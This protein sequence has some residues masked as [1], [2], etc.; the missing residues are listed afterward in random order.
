MRQ[1]G[2]DFVLFGGEQNQGGAGWSGNFE[3]RFIEGKGWDRKVETVFYFLDGKGW[4][5]PAAS[6]FLT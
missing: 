6:I 4:H 1:D 3:V 5:L 2:T